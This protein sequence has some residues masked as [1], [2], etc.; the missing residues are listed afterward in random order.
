M[1]MDEHQLISSLLISISVQR[2]K[3]Q[4]YEVVP[5]PAPGTAI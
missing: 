2:I 1:I 4:G 3:R 5:N